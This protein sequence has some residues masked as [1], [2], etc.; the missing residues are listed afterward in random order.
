MKA[1]GNANSK[2]INEL[3]KNINDRKIKIK[4][5]NNKKEDKRAGEN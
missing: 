4:M 2:N 1:Y 3:K 5:D